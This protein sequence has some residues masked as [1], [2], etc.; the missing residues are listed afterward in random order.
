MKGPSVASGMGAVSLSV[1]G[2]PADQMDLPFDKEGHPSVIGPNIG[3]NGPQSI[4]RG[5]LLVR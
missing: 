3:Q 4:R 1:K 5:A 2:A